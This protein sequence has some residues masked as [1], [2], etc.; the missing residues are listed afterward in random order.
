L[1]GELEL[2]WGVVVG[3]TLDGGSESYVA[4][5]RTDSGED[6]VVKLVMPPYEAFTSEL[7][8][9]LAS[10]GHGYVRLLNNDEERHAMLQERLGPSLRES[11]LPVPARMEILCATLQSAWE[12]PVPPGLPSGEEKARWLSGFIFSTWEELGRPCSRRVVEQ[13]L[14]FAAD[15]E[16]AFDPAAC[17]LVHGDAHDANALQALTGTR[18]RFKLVDPDGLL[19]EP[20]YDLG[21][22]MREWSGELLVGDATRLGRE[23]CAHLACL[24]GVDPRAIWEWGFVERV[25]TGLLATRVGAGRLGREMLD[26]AE[27]WATS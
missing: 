13:A 4:T 2:G 22:L 23:R 7:R 17:V 9:L 15:R 24:T 25:S 19:A 11:G 5:A 3:H 6:A 14:A 8:T 20:A 16:A 18:G 10:E 21:I 1:I 12:A 26:V 27:V